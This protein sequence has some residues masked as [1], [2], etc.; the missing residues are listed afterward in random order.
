VLLTAVPFAS[1][2]D[3]AVARHLPLGRHQA[4]DRHSQ[5]L[6]RPGHPHRS[7]SPRGALSV[8][9]GQEKHRHGGRVTGP[10]S[11]HPGLGGGTCEDRAAGRLRSAKAAGPQLTRRNAAQ[12]GARQQPVRETVRRA[13]SRQPGTVAWHH[14]RVLVP[15]VTPASTTM[16]SRANPDAGADAGRCT[17]FAWLPPRAGVL[18]R[19]SAR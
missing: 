3:L 8:C 6:R 10:G 14:A 18:P 1:S 13:L 11:S 15:A 9:G 19:S 17:G 16:L 7:S 2:D 4:G 5:V 12:G